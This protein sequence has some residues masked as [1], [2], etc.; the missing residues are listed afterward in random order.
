MPARKVTAIELSPSAQLICLHGK[1]WITREGSKTD[2]LLDAAGTVNF[3]T[4]SRLVIE[5]LE[6]SSFEIGSC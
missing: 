2:Y 6:D 3:P 4:S 5:A 1:L